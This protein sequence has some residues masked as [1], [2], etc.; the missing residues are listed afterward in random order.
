MEEGSYNKFI[1]GVV[2][3][4]FIFFTQIMS[5]QTIS[6]DGVVRDSLNNYLPYVCI[7]AKPDTINL[8]MKSVITDEKGRFHLDLKQNMTYGISISHIGYNNYNFNYA[9]LKNEEKAIYLQESLNQLNEVIIKLPM[10]VKQDTIIYNTDEFITGEEK[11]L[12]DILNKLPGIQVDENGEITSKGKAVT[13]TLVENKLFF[14]G[15]SKLAV[16]NIPANAIEQVILLDNYNEVSFLKGLID[17]DDLAINIKLKEKKKNFVFGDAELGKDLNDHYKAHSN[18]FYYNPILSFNFI[19]NI[20]NIGEKVFT[21]DDFINFLGGTTAAINNKNYNKNLKDL[22]QFMNQKDF[23]KTENKVGAFNIS[24]TIN[25]KITLSSYGIYS[26]ENTHNKDFRINQY[27][28]PNYSYTEKINNNEDIDSNF[29]LANFKS[30]Y[31]PSNNEEGY[32]KFLLKRADNSTNAKLVSIVDEESN[33]ISNLK[34]NSFITLE[35]QLAWH[36]KI[37]KTNTISLNSSFSIQSNKPNSIYNFGQ[38]NLLEFI[39]LTPSESYKLV[40]KKT[41]KYNDFNISLNHFY[42]INKSTQLTT[43]FGHERS[44]NKYSTSDLQQLSDAVLL[45]FSDQGFNNNLNFNLY[46][47]YLGLS[48]R[49]KKKIFQFEPGLIA[50]KYSWSNNQSINKKKDKIVLLPSLIARVKVNRVDR[51][52]LTYKLLSTF[53]EVSDFSTRYYINNYNQINIGNDSLENELKHFVSAVYTTNNL[54]RGTFLISQFTYINKIKGVQNIINTSGRSVVSSKRM[55]SF[56]SELFYGNIIFNKKIKNVKYHINARFSSSQNSEL[57][58]SE[59]INTKGLNANVG[60]SGKISLN[61]FPVIEI[62]YKHSV[63]QYTSEKYNSKF[64]TYEPFVNLNYYFQKK[65]NI[66]FNYSYFIRK[67]KDISL[68]D[69]YNSGNLIID[70]KK[71]ESPWNFKISALNLLN[72]STKKQQSFNRYIISQSETYLMPRVLMFSV[73]YKL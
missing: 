1:Q 22:S 56:P 57:I 73:L 35:G 39:S 42:V 34:N 48:L 49:F 41:K 66:A 30:K 65:I 5:S 47:T 2:F 50:H 26:I 54:L 15:N 29:L 52:K 63:N 71:E 27:I 25:S 6:L 23:L 38:F 14:G 40:S 17:T 53:S 43:K 10:I 44:L 62:G 20:N 60:L 28:I 59:L 36:K 68:S 4:V 37:S 55:A 9:A 8:R 24:K 12:K 11:K 69:S 61:N 13:H 3:F 64:S 32:L 72:D 21:Y 31:T 70:Y 16:E 51:I 67:N 45:N 46:D 7:I 58:N 33:N 18:L 19:G